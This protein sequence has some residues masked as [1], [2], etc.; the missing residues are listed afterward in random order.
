VEL[1]P[2]GSI[3]LQSINWLWQGWLAA[4]KLHILGG[5]PGTGKTTLAMSIAATISSG[6]LWADGSRAVKGG[7]VIWSAEDSPEDT[8]VP[9]LIQ[10]G[11][12]LEQISF[13]GKVYDPEGE[14]FFDPG[15]DIPTLRHDLNRIGEIRLLIVDPIVSAVTGNDHKNSEVRR[16]LQPLVELASDGS[17]AVLGIT[18]FSKNTAGRNPLDRI[19]GSLAF[20]AL[21]RVVWVTAKGNDDPPTR[22][23]LRAKSNIGSD[24]GGYE[25]SLLYSELT[26]NLGISAASVTWGEHVDG[27]ARMVL[28]A[29][30]SS[31]NDS[32]QSALAEAEEFLR[33]ALGS[34][35]VPY[36]SITLDAASLGITK[37]TLRRA[38]ESL[39]VK[40]E[41]LGMSQGWGWT[42]E[43]KVLK[44][45][46]GAHEKGSSTLGKIGHLQGEDLLPEQ[47]NQIREW[48]SR[49]GEMVSLEKNLAH[50]RADP[51]SLEYFLEISRNDS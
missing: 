48:H 1:I 43:P 38:K 4:G 36:E 10:C 37:S 21:A 51:K 14:R 17:C 47:I 25:Y 23:L 45:D 9:R 31:D 32:Q 27:S 20:G 16:S 29:I 6:G 18:H 49:E 35:P 8:L 2:A 12:D 34:A 42:F 46:E 7:V 15:T 28:D 33:N 24:D 40:S 39:G 26:N 3:K 30:E 5:A 11:A 22:L 41:K 13:I 19:T 50:C 44:K